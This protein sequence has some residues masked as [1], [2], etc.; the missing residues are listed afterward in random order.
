MSIVAAYALWIGQ[1]RARTHC[2]NSLN[3]FQEQP[4]HKWD[5]SQSQ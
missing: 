1:A 4:W 5:V 3:L 2:Q